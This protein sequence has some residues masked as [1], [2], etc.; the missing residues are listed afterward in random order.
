M[1]MN[2][3]YKLEFPLKYQICMDYLV[4]YSEKLEEAINNLN[5]KINVADTHFMESY[6]PEDSY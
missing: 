6:L 4:S 3:Y 2:S 1:Q 5:L